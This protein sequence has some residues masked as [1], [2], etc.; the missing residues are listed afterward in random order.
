MAVSLQ[1]LLSSNDLSTLPIEHQQNIKLL[2]ERINKVRLAYGK[3]MYVTSGYRSDK[4]HKEIYN[5]IN[6]KRKI[7]GLKEKVIPYGSKHLVGGACDI[8][9]P[10]RDLQEWCLSN[11]RLLEQIGL[12]M[13]DFEDTPTWVHFQIFSPLSNKRWFKP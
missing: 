8:S 10:K 9:D 5:R 7:A 2:L 12:W 13:E 4:Q 6:E 3:P 11:E 1:E